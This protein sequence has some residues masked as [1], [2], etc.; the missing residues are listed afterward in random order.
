MSEIY[1]KTLNRVY[2]DNQYCD[3]LNH[4]YYPIHEKVNSQDLFFKTSASLYLNAIEKVSDSLS[5]KKLLEVSY[6]RGGGARVIKQIYPTLDITACDLSAENI[7]FCKQTSDNIKFTVANAENLPYINNA[8]NIVLNIEASHCYHNRKKF[9]SEVHR[10]LK[11]DGI[12]VYSD[13]FANFVFNQEMEFSDYFKIEQR[14]DVTK[15][16]AESCE[17]MSKVLDG[18]PS[19]LTSSQIILNKK[20]FDSKINDYKTKEAIVLIY[21]LKKA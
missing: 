8:F 7:E 21:I 20:I 9:F 11:D 3:F 15:N 14:F 5:N 13:C 19:Q 18:N 10:V 17:Y 12:F 16:V 1:Y 2:K 6:G 4:G